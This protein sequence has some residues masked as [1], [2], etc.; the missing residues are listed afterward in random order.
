M[1]PLTME[2]NA[3]EG[4]RKQLGHALGKVPEVEPVAVAIF[5]GVVDPQKLHF[6][7]SHMQ[8]SDV[9]DWDAIRAWADEVAEKLTAGFSFLLDS[10]AAV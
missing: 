6:P 10:V 4:S 3:V 1:G 7:F 2:E 5:G 9:R 8:A